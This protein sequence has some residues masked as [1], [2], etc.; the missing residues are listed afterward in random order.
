MLFTILSVLFCVHCRVCL[1]LPSMGL[2][3][4]GFW[5]TSVGLIA[6]HCSGKEPVLLPRK[7]SWAHELGLGLKMCC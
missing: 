5:R 4:F 7:H 2:F 6:S 3:C 1:E